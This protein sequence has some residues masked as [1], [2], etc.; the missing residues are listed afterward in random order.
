MFKHYCIIA[1][2]N[3][4]KNKTYSII[5][6]CGLAIGIACSILVFL[7]VQDELSYDSFHNNVDRIFR[8][9]LV[10]KA[11]SGKVKYMAGQPL[12]LARTFMA[13]FP[14]IE[15][16]TR[17]I[18]GTAV[19]R[20]STHDASKEKVLFTDSDVFHIFSFPLS[21]GSIKT[22]LAEKN[23]ILISEAMAQRGFGDQ[24][25]WTFHIL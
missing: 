9:N 17:F 21:Q 20:S 25:W 8:V 1:F 5:N 16:V 4:Y 3:L 12:P 15:H 24:R 2:R 11:P 22:A 10:S 14:E 19:V 18:E 13:T 23:D 7:Y 6:V